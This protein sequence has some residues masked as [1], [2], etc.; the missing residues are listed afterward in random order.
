MLGL[1]EVFPP[2]NALNSLQPTMKLLS[3][4]SPKRES[5]I[6]VVLYIF[7]IDVVKSVTEYCSFSLFGIMTLFVWFS[8]AKWS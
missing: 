8:E 3:K 1:V 7:Q 2:G 4:D 6:H 5:F